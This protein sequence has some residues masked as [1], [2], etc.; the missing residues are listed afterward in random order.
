MPDVSVDVLERVTIG[1]I[2]VVAGIGTWAL[3]FLRKED[4]KTMAAID[5]LSEELAAR[6]TAVVAEF[7]EHRKGVHA[8][9]NKQEVTFAEALDKVLEKTAPM[10]H[11]DA[12]QELWQERFES[13][14]DVNSEQHAAI[15]TTMVQLTSELKELQRCVTLLGIGKECD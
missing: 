12:K 13:M 8:R 5:K 1:C 7:T 2:G 10:A 9:I 14:L 6:Q 4:D 3:R 11:C 15:G